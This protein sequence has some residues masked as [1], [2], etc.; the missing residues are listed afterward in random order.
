LGGVVDGEL[1]RFGESEGGR[2]PDQAREYVE[3][4]RRSKRYKRDVY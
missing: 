3:A 1:L 2:T 4:L